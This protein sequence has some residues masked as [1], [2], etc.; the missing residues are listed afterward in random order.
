MRLFVSVLLLTTLACATVPE[1]P[2][3]PEVKQFEIEGE[4][5][6]KEADIKR[7]ILT[8]ESSWS[9][10]SDPQYFDLNAWQGD[11]RR[12]E[13][14][15]EARGY[16][17]AKVEEN[18]VKPLG[19]GEVALRVRVSEGEP[20][21]I[22]RIDIKGL[23][24]LAAEFREEAL[25]DLPLQE[26]EIF[27][28]DDWVGV[29]E[30]IALNLRE[31]GFAEAS[32][33]GEVK[34]DVA[35]REASVELH[36]VPGLRYKF[37][38]IFISADP[39][40]KVAPRRIIEQARG[41]IKEQS[42]YS[43]SALS[44]AQ[45]RVFQMGVFGAVKVNRAAPNRANQTV[46]VVVEVRESPFHTVRSGGGIAFDQTRQQVRLLAEYTNRNFFG[47]LRRVTVGGRVGWA[48]IP[49][50]WDVI[51]NRREV[52]PQNG[53]IVSAITE[54]EQ[55]RFLFRD[56]SAQAS[57][58]L[59]R[60]LEQAYTFNSGRARVGLPWRPHPDFSIFP[61]YNVETYQALAGSPIL[62][63]RTPGLAFGCE[64]GICVLS[65]LEQVIEWDRRNDINEPKRGYYLAL[66]FQEGGGPLQGDFAFLRIQPDA[67][68]Y[69]SFGAE[70]RLTLA[71]K[72][73]IGTLI[74]LTGADNQT[75][76]VARFYSG[77]SASMR[78]FNTRRLSPL[79]LTQTSTSPGERCANRIDD[80]RDG[81]VDERCVVQTIAVGGN[82]L[83]E[84]TVEARYNV[85]GNLV[86]AAFVDT[87]FVTVE[88]F[89]F[90]N[91]RSQMRYAIGGGIRYRTPVGPVRFDF[92]HRLNIGS[93]LPL[94]SGQGGGLAV[95]RTPGCFGI[96]SGFTSGSP[97]SPCAFH[98]SIG[99]AF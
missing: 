23:E 18:E 14:Y 67:R 39:D 75:P 65:F 80:N 8:A 10:F 58:E 87:G 56:V 53:P 32:V 22:K 68:A 17:Q 16:Y 81:R 62:D 11:L 7:K 31:Q 78:G 47:G 46:P 76:L 33:T 72:L 34:V 92:A 52:A 3:G 12:I 30:Q 35:T 96:G 2:P 9:P 70:Q 85:A 60:G 28:E 4:E 97:E 84:S 61:S 55:P 69:V 5:A 93:A 79:L 59:E 13:R 71:A 15:Y 45:N 83:F 88:R 64:S 36:V 40:A 43:E 42:Y 48:F 63:S 38:D 25:E 41:A 26:G 44:E 86:L 91:L 1:V 20:T 98:I 57:V 6:L 19:E 73:K 99:E 49:T 77:G 66:S 82:G 95:P 29:K 54:F 51:R 24:E 90:G 27:V 50:S 89:D 21:R 94:V 37:G 74:P